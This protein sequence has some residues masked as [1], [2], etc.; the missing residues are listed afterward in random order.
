MLCFIHVDR[1]SNRHYFQG[2]TLEQ[3][4]ELKLSPAQ[5]AQLRFTDQQIEELDDDQYEVFQR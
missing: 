3:I 5:V 2:L 1:G 4:S